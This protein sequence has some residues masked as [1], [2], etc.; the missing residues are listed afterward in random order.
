MLLSCFVRSCP[1][2]FV[3]L[4]DIHNA[5]WCFCNIVPML[6]SL[7]CQS[8]PMLLRV[9]VRWW[10]CC[11]LWSSYYAHDA[12]VCS[13]HAHDNL[14]FCISCPWC[15]VF[16]VQTMPTILCLFS[17]WCTWCFGVY[18]IMPMLHRGLSDLAHYASFAAW[19]PDHA[20][21]AF[22]FI[23][24]C[25]WRFVFMTCPWS[26][27]RME[28]MLLILV[29]QIQPM[30]PFFSRRMSDKKGCQKYSIQYCSVFLWAAWL[31]NCFT[32]S[33]QRLT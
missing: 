23:R 22:V 5:T 10:Q 6:L 16:F 21:D 8:L 9:C 2:C 3:V 31:K 25:P 1:W 27:C 18:Q 26:C 33:F 13:D 29:C 32:V 4:S 12:F 15:L 20:H 7:C 14:F 11:L 28:L 19:L 30:R 24:S 17:K